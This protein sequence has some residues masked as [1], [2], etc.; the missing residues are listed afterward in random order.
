M[1]SGVPLLDRG[2][3]VIGGGSAGTYAAINLRNM[4][5]SVALIER[6]GRLGG[7]ANPF[8]DPDGDG[9][10]DI[11]VVVFENQ[12]WVKQYFSLLGVTSYEQPNFVLPNAYVDFNTGKT[13]AGYAPPSET[14]LGIA[15]ETCYQIL[16]TQF[17]YLSAGFQLPN[18][19]PADLLNPFGDFVTKYGLQS[20]VGTAFDYAQGVGNMLQVPALYVLK[21]FSQGVVYNIL[22][23]SFL[24][25]AGGTQ[26]IY[27]QALRILGSDVILNA[28]VTQASRDAGGVLV[29]V[30]SAQGPLVVRCNKLIVAFPPILQSLGPLGLDQ[31]ELSVF[32][33]LRANSYATALVELSGLP[34]EQ[35]LTNTSPSTPYNIP[36]LP[37][38]YGFNPSQ[39]PK[40]WNALFG[41]LTALPDAL[42]KQSIL[43]AINNM[44]AA[45]TYPVKLVDYRL[46]ANHTP[47]E[48]MTTPTIAGGFNH[49]LNAL[50]GRRS[51]FYTSAAF[52]TTDSSL[53]WLLTHSLLAS[54][55][56]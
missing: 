48:M 14:D 30:F 31:S 34:P 25:I 22:Q 42:I 39:D 18:P 15:L 45:G 12:P 46:Y 24:S 26:Q 17:P 20:L 51:T 53:I 1:A 50:Q 44:A 28:T 11:G 32:S 4:G 10:I 9:A 19:A 38:L 2:V 52:Q 3:C 35:A 8:I 6:T 56:A 23:G 47:F 5:E 37:G 49:S 21:N 13:V 43:S 36:S 7:H 55:V 16:S 41:S 33:Q 54:I 29:N 40:L 27:N